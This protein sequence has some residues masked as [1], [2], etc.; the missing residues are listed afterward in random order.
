MDMKIIERLSREYDCDLTSLDHPS[1][2][3][4]F[5][6]RSKR[7]NKDIF[8]KLYDSKKR[9]STELAILEVL[10]SSTLLGS[11]E[12]G[13]CRAVILEYCDMQDVTEMSMA[14]AYDYG[15]LLG[16]FHKVATNERTQQI[17]ELSGESSTLFA[18]IDETIGRISSH[19]AY[20][21]VLRIYHEL[22]QFSAVYQQEYE[23]L[24]KVV[25]HGDFGLRNIKLVENAPVLI[26]F[27]RSKYDIAWMD[28]VKFFN[29]E[30]LD[31]NLQARFL[32][33]YQTQYPIAVPTPLLQKVLEFYTAIGIYSYTMHI[34]DQAFRL[35]GDRMIHQIDQFCADLKVSA[36]TL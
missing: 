5:S 2:N 23:A 16:R 36:Q 20:A 10:Q 8:V 18:R 27:E 19:P 34:P 32:E 35:M 30:A 9:C 21:K 13:E 26:D 12:Y 17:R 7:L 29:R 11:Y 24:P 4:H 15:I 3:L 22:S 1:K 33:G 28:L 6:G 25:L 14:T 31:E